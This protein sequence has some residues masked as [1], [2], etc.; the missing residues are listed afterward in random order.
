MLFIHTPSLMSLLYCGLIFI[1]GAL[2]ASSFVVQKRPDAADTLKSLQPYKG[3]IGITALIWS[4]LRLLGLLFSSSSAGGFFLAQVTSLAVVGSGILGG[5]LLSYPLI[6]EHFLSDNK[7][8]AEKAAS[9]RQKLLVY[10]QMIGLV[11]MG[12]AALLLILLLF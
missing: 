8:A 4:V 12:G 2:A 6:V 11:A 10:E 1:M 5:F 9:L 7:E 3:A